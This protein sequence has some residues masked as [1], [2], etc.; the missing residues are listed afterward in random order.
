[1]RDG[2][3]AIRSALRELETHHYLVRAQIRALGATDDA[4]V[5]EKVTEAFTEWQNT[6]S[7][8]MTENSS[9]AVTSE[10]PDLSTE[11]VDK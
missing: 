10:K 8:P 7:R 1:M 9:S 2:R 3:D 4:L 6:R 11:P 5:A